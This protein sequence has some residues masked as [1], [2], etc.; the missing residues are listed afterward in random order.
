MNTDL[1]IIIGNNEFAVEYNPDDGG[2][3][4]SVNIL[5]EF[6]TEGLMVTERIGGTPSAKLMS[7]DDAIYAEAVQAYEEHKNEEVMSHHEETYCEES[8]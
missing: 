5:G 8:K 1:K 6:S 4:E 7:L 3:I 2:S